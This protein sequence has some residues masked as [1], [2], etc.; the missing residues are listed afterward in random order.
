MCVCF[1]ESSLSTVDESTKKIEITYLSSSM[2]VMPVVC[3]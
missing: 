2:N 1:Q 3:L